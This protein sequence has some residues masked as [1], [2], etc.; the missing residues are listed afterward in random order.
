MEITDFGVFKMVEPTGLGC[1]Y[2]RDETG[3]DWY[4]LRNRLANWKH[5]DGTPTDAVYGAW[6]L[7]D[8]QTGMIVCV[9]KTPLF[10]SPHYHRVLGIDADPK[11]VTIGMHY[12]DGEI[13]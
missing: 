11:D 13:E 7:A 12:K 9:E 8:V 10:L 4:E 5:E 2:F 6:A 1:L 3:Q